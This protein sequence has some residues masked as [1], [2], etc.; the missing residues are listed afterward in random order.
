MELAAEYNRLFRGFK[1]VYRKKYW[2]EC[3]NYSYWGIYVGDENIMGDLYHSFS[4]AFTFPRGEQSISHM[5]KG[6]YLLPHEVIDRCR[7]LPPYAVY[8]VNSWN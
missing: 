6:L 8:E 1:F 2:V 5:H 3:A 7:L 4:D